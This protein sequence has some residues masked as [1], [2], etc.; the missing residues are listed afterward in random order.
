MTNNPQ[1]PMTTVRT[2]ALVHNLC[3]IK[4]FS[5]IDYKWN[6]RLE[7]TINLKIRLRN[8]TV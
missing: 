8:D 1:N 7:L 4:V 3:A 5:M 6:K 2:R